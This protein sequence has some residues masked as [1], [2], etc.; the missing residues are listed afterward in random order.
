M[1]QEISNFMDTLPPSLK[2]KG[3]KPK[4]GIHAL[5]R[6]LKSDD[7]DIYMDSSS[8]EKVCYTKRATEFDH[9]FLQRCAYYAQYAWCVNTNKC[10][11]LPAKGIH[12]CSPYCIGFKKESLEGGGKYA[13]DKEKI[14]DRINSYFENAYLFVDEQEKERLKVFQNFINSKEKLNALISLFAEEF[15][16]LGEKEYIVLYLDEDIEKYRSMNE[17]YLTDKLFNTND[18]NKKYGEQIFGTSDFLNGF[19]S[20]KPFLVH[21][22]ATFDIAGRISG[23]VARNLYEFQDIL[24]RNILP[25]PLPIFVYQEELE[26]EFAVVSENVDAGKK[27]GY[28][29]VIEKMNEKYQ[30][31]IGNY[32][33]L[34]FQG[35]EVKDFDF[36]SKFSYRLRGEQNDYWE[37]KDY[38][39]LKREQRIYNVFE[40]ELKVLKPI[41]N[42]SLIVQTKNG[43]VLYK[44]FDEIDSKY[45]KPNIYILL[46][47]Y[48]KAFY[49]YIYKSNRAAVTKRMFDDILLTSVLEGIRSDEM[50]NGRHTEGFNILEKMNIW[51]SL[52]DQF[53]INRKNNIET[54][55]NRIQR[56]KAFIANLIEEKVSIELDDE[57]AFALGQVIYYLFSKSETN[58]RGYRRLEPFMQQNNVL[59]LQQ[60]TAKLFDKHK[61]EV[62]SKGFKCV[63]SEVMD[64]ESTVDMR[65]YIPVMLSG[66]FA[67]NMLFG[68][69]KSEEK[70]EE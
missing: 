13:S 10:F 63:F 16:L 31:D 12:S 61:H 54:M 48:R 30:E 22:S 7:G 56:H 60:A 46:M 2:E 3:I 50:E 57:F 39:G 23:K 21:Q 62:Y 70:T 51:F 6:L 37:I 44:Y 53:D 32:Y 67:N 11:D 29:E 5:L 49:N 68:E 34:F 55:G 42:N 58:D 25:R 43:D 69:K 52:S 4:E 27:I 47:K 17:K 59:A 14:Y 33:L 9:P 38:F 41:F 15:A 24:K 64:Y 66:F 8:V 36:V 28:K 65:Q 45:C 18:Y 40:L 26:R 35:G 19:P 1:I 20:K